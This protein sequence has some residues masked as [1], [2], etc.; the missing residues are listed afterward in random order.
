MKHE[1]IKTEKEWMRSVVE[2]H[3][4]ELTRYATSILGD[5]D[6]AKDVV[7]DSFI[8]L[9]REPREQIADHVR[10]WLFRVCRNR[11]L[12]LK[13]KVARMK[14]L[15]EANTTKTP[16]DAPGPGQV[17]EQRDS[18]AQLLKLIQSLPENQ[19][20]VVRLKFQND[21]SYKEIADVTQLSVSNVGF[22]LHTAIKTLRAKVIASGE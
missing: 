21:L 2:A 5:A 8:R 1:Q 13:R 20:E 15:A 7:Q 11:A 3:A 18:S 4:A 12:D 9:W 17:T 10:P 22:L 16:V 6:A 19:R 14:P